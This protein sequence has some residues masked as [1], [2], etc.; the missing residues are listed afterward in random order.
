M[1]EDIKTFEF[2]IGALS[3]SYGLSF[4]NDVMLRVSDDIKKLERYRALS[5]HFDDGLERA[6]SLLGGIPPQ[7]IRK[8]MV[9]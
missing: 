2:V 4:S 6:R 5:N 1:L 7:D 8:R 9:Y 3:N